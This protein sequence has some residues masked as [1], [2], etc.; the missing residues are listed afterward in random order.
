MFDR[1][2][3]FAA[4]SFHS[5]ACALLRSAIVLDKPESRIFAERLLP[6]KRLRILPAVHFALRLSSIALCGSA[7]WG[8]T[9][10]TLG[11]APAGLQRGST[12]EFYQ[13][14]V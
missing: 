10:R 2:D 5:R 6:K 9:A 1:C 7:G 4:T 14:L 8:L 11:R 13:L 3:I 12:L